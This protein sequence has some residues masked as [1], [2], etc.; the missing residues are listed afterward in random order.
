M[1]VV[2]A[3]RAHGSGMKVPEICERR[4]KTL[5]AQLRRMAS[6]ERPLI[7]ARLKGR[8]SKD[9]LADNHGVAP[10]LRKQ[11]PGSPFLVLHRQRRGRW[12]GAQRRDVGGCWRGATADL[13]RPKI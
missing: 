1:S 8:S 6:N 11:R 9:E 5:R 10:A 13:A 7:R 12:I 3:A 2:S 4:T